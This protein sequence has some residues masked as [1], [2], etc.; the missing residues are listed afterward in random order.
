MNKLHPEHALLITVADGHANAA[1]QQ[2]ANELLKTDAAAAEFFSSLEQTNLDY[3]EAFDIQPEVPQSLLTSIEIA[4]STS[5]ASFDGVTTIKPHNKVGG[6]ADARKYGNLALAASL[7]VGSLV[8]AL[9]YGVAGTHQSSDYVSTNIAQADVPEW[10]RLV[11]DYHRLYV[12]ETI[13]GVPV[14][15]KD[16]VSEAVSEKLN[17]K[18]TVPSLDQQGMEFRRAQWL[19]VDEQP[20]LQLAYLPTE[21]EPLAVC[22]LRKNEVRDLP[23][24]YGETGGM[25][26]VHWQAGNLAVVIVG[27]VDSQQLVEINR[28]VESELL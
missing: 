21:G 28:I 9:I 13:V 1:E 10:V 19:A 2:R 14:S 7:L 6:P 18:L 3:S 8:G 24:E 26:Y 22:V 25:Q 5:L 11:A 27:T 16:L 20:L 15:S 12:R 17:H 4:D 23:A